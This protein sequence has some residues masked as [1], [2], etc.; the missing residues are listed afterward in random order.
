M[1]AVVY[2]KGGTAYTAFVDSDLDKRD[3]TVYG[4][5][6]S[7][8]GVA[9]AWFAGF[10]EDSADRSISIAIVVEGG[11]SGSRDA[12]PLGRRMIELCNEFGYVGMD[13]AGHYGGEEGE[14][15]EE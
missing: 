4:K 12:A 11:T 5:T 8:Q 2:E 1:H 10:A 15:S 3:V 13:I 14:E 6:G 9:T 7:T